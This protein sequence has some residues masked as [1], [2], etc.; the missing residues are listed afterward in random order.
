M[1]SLLRPTVGATQGLAHRRDL[2]DGTVRPTSNIEAIAII[3][4]LVG[5]GTLANSTPLAAAPV[6][7]KFVRQVL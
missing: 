7:P 1:L 3:T 2:T 4:A 6:R 5:S